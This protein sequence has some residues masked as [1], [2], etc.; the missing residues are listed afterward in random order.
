MRETKKKELSDVNTYWSQYQVVIW[1]SSITAGLDCSVPFDQF[2]HVFVNN[3]TDCLSFCQ[4]MFRIRN[5]RDAEHF[6]FIEDATT[7][8]AKSP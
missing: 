2:Y 1:T 3:T 7:D 4:G 5:Y 8:V 6:L